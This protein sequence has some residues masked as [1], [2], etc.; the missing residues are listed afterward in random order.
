MQIHVHDPPP[1]PLYAELMVKSLIVNM[2]AK[3]NQTLIMVH[4]DH[5]KPRK[6]KAEV[7]WLIYQYYIDHYDI[8]LQEVVFPHPCH[9]QTNRNSQHFV[10]ERCLCM[11]I[12]KMKQETMTVK[13]LLIF[14]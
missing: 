10:K 1:T 9:Q 13:P 8:T 14:N 5:I 4:N 12:S 3:Q 11:S 6:V 7:I 2:Q